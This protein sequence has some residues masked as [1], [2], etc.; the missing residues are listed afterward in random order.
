MDCLAVRKTKEVFGLE[1]EWK[2]FAINELLLLLYMAV[3]PVAGIFFPVKWK[4]NQLEK[5]SD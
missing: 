1:V 2:R 3:M 4:E 5:R